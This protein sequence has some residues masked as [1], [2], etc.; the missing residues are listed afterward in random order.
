MGKMPL[1]IAGG[2][3][4]LAPGPVGRQQSIGIGSDHSLEK[5]YSSR[6]R[7]GTFCCSECKVFER[8]LTVS[9]VKHEPEARARGDHAPSGPSRSSG[10]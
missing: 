8:S 10:N 1:S 2:Q 6:S 9:S 7:L 4:T 3:A 5:L